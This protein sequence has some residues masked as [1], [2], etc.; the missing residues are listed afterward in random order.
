MF[1]D[2]KLRVRANNE[3]E[4]AV[5]GSSNG[6]RKPTA[7]RSEHRL[8]FIQFAYGLQRGELALRLCLSTTVASLTTTSM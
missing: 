2:K 8:T 1:D 5:V 3:V 6:T 7:R 4:T